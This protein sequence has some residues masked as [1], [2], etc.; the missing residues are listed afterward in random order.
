MD[1]L[2]N[3]ARTGDP[4]PYLEPDSPVEWTPS[5]HSSRLRTLVLGSDS[6]RMEDGFGDEAAMHFVRKVIWEAEVEERS[7]Q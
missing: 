6:T 7:A 5:L 4:S 3:F 2:T 1:F